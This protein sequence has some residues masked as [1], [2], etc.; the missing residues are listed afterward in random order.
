MYQ[1]VA[2]THSVCQTYPLSNSLAGN[3][4]GPGDKAIVKQ[5]NF[6]PPQQQLMPNWVKFNSEI[7]VFTGPNQTKTVW[8]LIFDVFQ[9][10]DTPATKLEAF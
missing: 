7:Q 3:S 2:S 8:R 9:P 6:N 4:E 10:S 1:C 5:T